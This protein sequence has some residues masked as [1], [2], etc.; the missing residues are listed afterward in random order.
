M[1]NLRIFLFVLA[2]VTCT[3]FSSYSG[4]IVSEVVQVPLNLFLVKNGG[5][6][7]IA[8][9]PIGGLIMGA[10][11]GITPWIIRHYVRKYK[12]YQAEKQVKRMKEDLASHQ[13]QG[14][15][16]HSLPPKKEHV[17]DTD[18]PFDDMENREEGEIS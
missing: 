10:A 15:S 8:P 5:G 6:R 13:Q 2:V 14:I 17:D 12:A 9:S 1:N 18:T 4:G 7:I 16:C 3:S 11:L